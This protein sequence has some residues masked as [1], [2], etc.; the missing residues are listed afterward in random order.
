MNC[1]NWI[2]FECRRSNLQTDINRNAAQNSIFWRKYLTQAQFLIN[3]YSSCIN[4][5]KLFAVFTQFF[6]YCNS[7]SKQV[8][9]SKQLRVPLN[10]TND[11]ALWYWGVSRRPSIVGEGH[12]GVADSALD[13]SAPCRFLIFF[14]YSWRKTMKQAISWM[15][16][17][18]NLLK[19]ESS[20]LPRAKRATN[21]N[22]VA[23]E[24]RI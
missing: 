16:L 14:F 24:Q 19:L 2:G 12:F 17:S 18:A 3:K 6:S 23:T 21:R 10:P 1:L 11:T 4:K 13:N 15:P 7:K 20:I 8:L 22:N 9:K 5:V